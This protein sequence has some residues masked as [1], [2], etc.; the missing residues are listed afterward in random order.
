MISLYDLIDASDGQLLGEPSTQLFES[1]CLDAE[2]ATANQ[3]F[4]ILK[5]R[6]GDTH[7]DIE[8]AIERGVSGV[9][10]ERPPECA[11]D[12]VSVV[13]V[14]DTTD[15]LLAWSRFVL[16]K[17]GTKVIGVSGSI[18]KSTAGDALTHILGTRYRV[19]FDANG[20]DGRLS[21]PLAVSRLDSNHEMAV[22]RLGTTRVG[23]MAAM[24]EAA[25]PTVGLVTY[26]GTL[27]KDRFLSPAEYAQDVGILIKNLSP[28]GLA[29]LNY[30]DDLVRL[31]GSHTHAQVKTVG[32]T[33]FGADTMAYNVS[34]NIGGTQF[35]LRC[36]DERYTARTVPVLGEQHLYGIVAALSI[37]LHFGI[38]LED[39]LSALT[40]MHPLPGRMNPIPGDNGARV[41]DDTFSTSPQSCLAAINW[42][43]A[44][45]D[46][47]KRI[48]FV[49]GDLEHLGTTKETHYRVLGQRAVEVADVLITKGV[50]AAI[51]ARSAL[52]YGMPPNKVHSTFA[53]QD[54][55]A[56]LRN[57]YDLTE[58]DLVLIKGGPGSNVDKTVIGLSQESKYQQSS[59]HKSEQ[60]KTITVDVPDR[61]SW[62]EINTD[63]L[64]G[65]VRTLKSLVG[66]DVE[67]LA[68]VKADGYGHGAIATARTALLNGATHLGVSSIQE[69]AE[70]RSVGID[71]PILVMNLVP[72]HL[73]ALAIQQNITVSVFDLKTAR[74]YDRIAHD[75]G[76][77]LSVHIK[78]DSGMGR[79]GIM[80]GQSSRF[81]RHLLNMH[82]IKVEGIFTHFSTADGD[83]EFTAQQ[84]KTFTDV[85]RTLMNA[86]GHKFRFVHAANS[87]AMLTNPETHFNMV[88]PGI[89]LYGLHPSQEV[90]LPT[91][92]NPVMTWKTT[93]VQVKTLPPGHAI[94]YGNTY[95]TTDEERIAILPVGYA[96]GFRRGPN[97]WGEVLIHGQRAPLVGRVSMEKTAVSVSHID[98]VALGDE[99]VLLGSQG[100]ETITAEEIANRLGTINYEVVCGISP[101]I[102]RY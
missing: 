40:K 31:M 11:T 89:A 20:R 7:H 71:A 79:L 33:T 74:A 24:V 65:N 3:L 86:T 27:Q 26:L 59:A 88:R 51:A 8:G 97:N 50:K 28:N 16:G 55:L 47:H 92:F 17:L 38:P 87:A 82:H 45:R 94:G 67:I 42:L 19:H 70:L 62:V 9:L 14:P 99:V 35:D 93:V 95:I 78:V 1:L 100:N 29:V 4:V 76:G 72:P 64:A 56:V 41:I 81:L 13:L 39:G 46:G 68:V 96:D 32:L 84:L 15:A 98:D 58:D 102:P 77:Q 90:Q 66:E 80:P 69:A 10:C 101:R 85:L 22:I 25:Q 53:Q 18:G 63:A 57:L 30:D 43:A 61:L 5:D 75:L 52:D 23:E 60:A 6:H 73:G 34:T 36:G 44:V 37:G 21:I 54:T 12:G 91:G 49:L 2:Q 83:P 48:F